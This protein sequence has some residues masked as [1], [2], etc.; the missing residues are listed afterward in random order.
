M[1][2]VHGYSHV[3]YSDTI[4]PVRVPKLNCKS[5]ASIVDIV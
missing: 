1:D 3:K 5:V 2:T 4:C